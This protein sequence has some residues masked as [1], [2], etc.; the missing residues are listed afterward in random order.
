MNTIT[1]IT[2]NNPNPITLNILKTD[3]QGKDERITSEEKQQRIAQRKADSIYI[4]NLLQS[5]KA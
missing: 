1:I 5:V 3:A 2:P 4:L